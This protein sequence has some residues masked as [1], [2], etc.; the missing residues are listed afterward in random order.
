ADLVARVGVPQGQSVLVGLNPLVMASYMKVFYENGLWGIGKQGGAVSGL[1]L[2]AIWLAEAGVIVGLA[3]LMPWSDFKQNV[4]CEACDNWT[5][6]EKDVVRLQDVAGDE[7]SRRVVGG[8]F[9]AL[10]D[11]PKAPLDS[12]QF[13]RIN[14]ACC[15]SCAETNALELERVTIKLDKDNKPSEKTSTLFNRLLISNAE[16]ELA[17]GA[18]IL[19]A[20][21]PEEP[22]EVEIERT[23]GMPHAEAEPA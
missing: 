1:P 21:E 6:V 23:D 19:E 10:Q 5:K 11:V 13:L 18:G 8:D 20:T 3:G 17:R 16:V 9:A 12:M 7:L 14:L 4:F 15:E 2:L 22:V